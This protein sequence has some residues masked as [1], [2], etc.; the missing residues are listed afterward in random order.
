VA[1]PQEAALSVTL[2]WAARQNHRLHDAKAQPATNALNPEA[3]SR[4]ELGIGRCSHHDDHGVIRHNNPS[5]VH[6]PDI[7]S[8]SF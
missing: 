7:A 6:F 8:A 3:R 1:V 2:M 4:M 5:R